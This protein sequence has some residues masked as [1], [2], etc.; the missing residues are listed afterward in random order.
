MFRDLFEILKE[1]VKKLLTSRTF[2]LG[3]VFTFLFS[4][5]VI[6]LFRLQIIEGED[7]QNDYMT[8]TEKTVRIASTRG[9][10]FDKN[11]NVLAYNKL[12]YNVTIQDKGDYSGSAERNR[13]LLELVRILSRH[14]E[15]VQG[16]FSIGLDLER[17][18]G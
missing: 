9:N 8:L 2:I 12:A 17:T 15:K 13:M 16:D 4:T 3:I 18:T 10:I 7:Y 11:G 6:R 14:G 1:Y 5:L